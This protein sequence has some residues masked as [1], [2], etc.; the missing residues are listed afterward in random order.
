MQIKETRWRALY[1]LGR[2]HLALNDDRQTAETYFRDAIG[3]I[4]SM[5]S[6][7]KVKELKEN[8]MQ[9]RLDVYKDL[10]K[11]LAD[12]E[13]PEAAFEI[14]ER[15]RSRNFIDLLGTQRVSLGS[16]VEAE[17]YDKQATLAGEIEATQ[18]L[19]ATAE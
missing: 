19:L 3:I 1:G 10:V 13:K 17:L 15:S 8:F 5:R 14:A 2:T 12:M 4:E 18:Q 11:L 6:A 9:N 7:I 16:G